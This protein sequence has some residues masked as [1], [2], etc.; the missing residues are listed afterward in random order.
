MLMES[1]RC[2]LPQDGTQTNRVEGW[3]GIFHIFSEI[4]ADRSIVFQGDRHYRSGN[5]FDF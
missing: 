4:A 5:K 3:H 1:F 2:S